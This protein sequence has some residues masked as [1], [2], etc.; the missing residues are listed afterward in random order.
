MNGVMTGDGADDAKKA[1]K[2]LVSRQSGLESEDSTTQNSVR[3]FEGPYEPADLDYY[4]KF[5]V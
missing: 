1:G 2:D 5:P 4:S 3:K